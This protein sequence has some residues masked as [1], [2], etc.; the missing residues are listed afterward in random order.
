[1]TAAVKPVSVVVPIKGAKRLTLAVD[2][3]RRGGVQDFVD[4]ADAKLFR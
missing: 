2:A 4:W 1:M 3:A